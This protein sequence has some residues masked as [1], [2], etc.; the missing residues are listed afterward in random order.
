ME[1]KFKRNSIIFLFFIGIVVLT[2]GGMF[3]YWQLQHALRF[4]K[5]IQTS[6]ETI[7]A[8]NQAALSIDEAATDLT[9]F[10]NTTDAD[11]IGNLPKLVISV[12]IN[13]AALDQ[14]TRDNTDELNIIKDI[15]PLV[16]KK[17]VFYNT[18]IAQYATGDKASAMQTSADKERLNINKQIIQKI[19]EVKHIE[20]LQL[21]EA[22]FN[23][24]NGLQ[25][26][27]FI[28]LSTGILCEFLF[29]ISYIVLRRY[30]K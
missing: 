22:K 7:N 3:F 10:L 17:I 18:I 28:F 21:Q 13:F 6:Y 19:I 30:L 26:A 29:L 4:E 15:K 8:A 1:Q 2:I 16:D 25:K 24:Q 12:K 5:D 20:V 27:E 14:L 9:R 23:F 11:N